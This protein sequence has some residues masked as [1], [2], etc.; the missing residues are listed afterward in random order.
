MYNLACPYQL[1][2]IISANCCLW[3]VPSTLPCFLDH[4][5]HSAKSPKDKDICFPEQFYCLGVVARS[6]NWEA[7][8]ML[9]AHQ[10]PCD[11]ENE[12]DGR[13]RI[14]NRLTIK[15]PLCEDAVHHISV[16]TYKRWWALL[17]M[18][19]QVGGTFIKVFSSLFPSLMEMIYPGDGSIL[20]WE[21]NSLSYFWCTLRINQKLLVF[22]IKYLVCSYTCMLVTYI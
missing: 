21:K 13:Q 5:K 6:V 22:M 17:G 4:P 16:A 11:I 1:C 20:A 2:S 14:I 19:M 8:S 12:S 10:Y 15:P 3:S 7:V 9:D 18:Y